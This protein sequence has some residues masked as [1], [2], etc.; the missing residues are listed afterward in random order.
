M[1]VGVTLPFKAQA[2]DFTIARGVGSSSQFPNEG[3]VY[4][5]Y[6]AYS[7]GTSPYGSS[8]PLNVSNTGGSAGFFVLPSKY[9]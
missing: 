9:A 3:D 8:A 5:Y 4:V 7:T 6:K 1:V 2:V